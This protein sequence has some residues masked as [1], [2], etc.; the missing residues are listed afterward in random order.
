MYKR[1]VLRVFGAGLTLWIYGSAAQADTTRALHPCMQNTSTIPYQALTY[2]SPANLDAPDGSFKLDGLIVERL[3][4]PPLAKAKKQRIETFLSDQTTTSE[5]VATKIA[6]RDRYGR[7]SIFI[8]KS[9]IPEN[10]DESQTTL[11]QEALL[12]DGLARVDPQS[13]S[14]ACADRLLAIENQARDAE[15]GIWRI[16]RYQ[17]KDATKLDLSN[18][19]SRYQI[20]HGT[21]KS[22]SRNKDRTSYLNFGRNWQSD[23]TVSLSKKSLAT[24]EEKNKSLDEL[25]QAHI[26]VRGWVE[27][28]GGPLI[29]VLRP[30]QLWVKQIETDALQAGTDRNLLRHIDDK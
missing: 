27:D 14:A 23:F 22:I 1:S 29:R 20:I 30:Q 25:S 11:L 18:I 4:P 10:Q 7:Q 26:Y 21:V 12:N 19:V 13:V 5:M 9:G 6:K 16:P 8:A 2:T 28:R 15:K 3:T 24:W 17:A